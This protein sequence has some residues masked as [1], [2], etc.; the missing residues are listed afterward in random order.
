MSEE[1]KHATTN[2]QMVWSV[3]P[4][5]LLFS[6]SL[7]DFKNKSWANSSMAFQ[8]GGL[9]LASGAAVSMSNQC[10]IDV[11]SMPKRSLT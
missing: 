7:F 9:G 1:D 4:C 10:R 2:V 3:S 8:L 5:S 6:F 11:K